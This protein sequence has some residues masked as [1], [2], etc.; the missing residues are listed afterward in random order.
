MHL[1]P[2]GMGGAKRYLEGANTGQAER[3][4]GH[5]TIMGSGVGAHLRLGTR[6][7]IDSLHSSAA[8]RALFG[9]NPNEL[10]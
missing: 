8:T 1:Q 5:T 4:N 7:A 9:L 6:G 3:Q 10:P 2:L